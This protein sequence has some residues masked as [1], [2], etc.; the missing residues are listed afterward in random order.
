MLQI[1]AAMAL[2]FGALVVAQNWSTLVRGTPGGFNAPIPL[3]GGVA[4]ALGLLGFER[5]RPLWW[6][7][8]AVDLGV[9]TLP[10]ALLAAIREARATSPRRVVR[11][12][13]SE[14]P[15]RRDVFTLLEKGI[16]TLKSEFNPPGRQAAW[17]GYPALS[18][19]RIG[20]WEAEADGFAIHGFEGER[21][22]RI[23]RDGGRFRTTEAGFTPEKEADRLDGLLLVEG[24]SKSG[25][26]RA[27]APDRTGASAGRDG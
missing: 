13:V 23:V 4:L 17:E 15:T 24:A 12:F 25:S 19:S 27:S 11:R 3:V 14:T 18:R 10:F 2:A 16:V 20:R 9:I 5:T 6:V 26:P 1:L 8:L 22:V 7:G 21:V